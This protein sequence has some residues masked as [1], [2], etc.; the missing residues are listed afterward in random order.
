M[1]RILAGIVAVPLLIACTAAVAPSASGENTELSS[2]AVRSGS[3][4]TTVGP[5]HF[6][7]V[8]ADD[9]HAAAIDCLAELG[10]VTG[11][12]SGAFRPGEPVTR[13]QA[14]SLV[15]RTTLAAGRTLPSPAE[16][17]GDLEGGAHDRA[18]LRLVAAEVVTGFPDGL[19][20]PDRLL[21]RGQAATLLDGMWRLLGL[22]PPDGDHSRFRDTADTVHEHA[23]SALAE[24]EVLRGY[25]DGS[26]RPG[27]AVTRAQLASAVD[28][29]LA[30][31]SPKGLDPTTAARAVDVE[32]LVGSACL[33]RPYDRTRAEG[34]LDG[35]LILDPHP[36]TKLPTQPRWDEDPFSDRNWRFQYHALRWLWSL[37]HTGQASEDPRYLDRALAL[38]Q[39]WVVAN[40]FESPAD[41]FAW[42]DHATAWRALVL[43]CLQAAQEGDPPAWF[44]DTV[45]EHRT[46][47][48]DPDFYVEVGNHALNQD[49]GLLVLACLTGGWDHRDLAAE[50]ITELA[51]TSIDPEG[52]T[53]EQSAEY[54]AYNYE[55]YLA[56]AQLLEACGLPPTRWED[57]LARMPVV[58]S[59][60]TQPDG[61][62]VQ[63][64]DTDRKPV[65]ARFTHP[66]LRWFL[67]EG[68]E[69]APPEETFVTYAA[70]F[71]V[72]RTGW[73]APGALEDEGFMSL[74]HG[75]PPAFHGHDD[76]G[77]IT[78]F[79]DSQALVVDPGKYAYEDGPERDHALHRAAHSTVTIGASCGT[80]ATRPSPVL[81]RRSDEG[82]DITV[83][84]V[85]T[86]PGTG[87]VRTVAFVRATGE[88][89]VV[90]E[91]AVHD[92]SEVVQH[93]QLEA[94]AEVTNASTEQVTV[95]WPS[96]ARLRIDQLA[97][98]GTVD[99]A[100][101]QIEP[102]RG[103]I[104]PQYGELESAPN[105]AFRRSVTDRDL[106]VTV[107]R[108]G[109]EG[110]APAP[111]A[112]ISGAEVVVTLP[113][114]DGSQEFG[115]PRH[116]PELPPQ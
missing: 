4:C 53:N 115:L 71:T 58:L 22:P 81:D 84:D 93:W 25:G 47:L 90:D 43:G 7:D 91:V 106:L 74:R 52:V 111:R 27:Q 39:S 98:R 41:P 63:L 80:H 73:G 35:R 107:L 14:A 82:A 83:V 40:P 62:L 109:S 85:A 116:A 23:I 9:V 114:A 79:G 29:L 8:P 37:M 19:L 26:F 45:L 33:Q 48:A 102:R 101:G 46:R 66:A 20:H 17:T 72:A 56:A 76:H 34:L 69:G 13:G 57:R 12:R 110:D 3:W 89:V 97:P 49:T 96:G 18:L 87:W 32:R 24:L 108:P 99:V 92:R 104:S 67:T 78:L 42:N 54:Q 30:A 11:D 113:R 44:V 100:A 86:C 68:R 16:P 70:G 36:E 59:H 38:T 105:L 6:P 61:T 28:R 103:W 10:I 21:T 94:G 88:V 60:L 95:A 51:M 2:D 55:R 15:L 50:R 112:T 65:K 5:G 64:G 1:W 75:P 77:S 31:G